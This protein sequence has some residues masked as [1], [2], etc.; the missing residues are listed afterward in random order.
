M[1][2]QAGLKGLTAAAIDFSIMITINKGG[3]RILVLF[4]LRPVATKQA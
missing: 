1:R 2:F 4:I 3:R